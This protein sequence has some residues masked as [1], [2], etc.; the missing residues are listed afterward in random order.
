[1][2]ACSKEQGA[3]VDQWRLWS[4]A[5]RSGQRLS[6]PLPTLNSGDANGC[7]LSVPC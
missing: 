6:A 7:M 1:M 5:Q 4:K 2:Q 3:N